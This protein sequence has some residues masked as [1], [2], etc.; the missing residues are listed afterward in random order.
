MLAVACPHLVGRD[1]SPGLPII[2]RMEKEIP[3]SL[4]TIMAC[5]KKHS[6]NLGKDNFDEINLKNSNNNCCNNNVVCL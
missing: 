1:A 3:N 5:T 6:F 4:M 2:T